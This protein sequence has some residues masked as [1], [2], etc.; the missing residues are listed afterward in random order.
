MAY[1]FITK[2]L[3]E[4]KDKVA[5]GLT[6]RQILCFSPVS[7]THLR[8]HE[9]QERF[10]KEVEKLVSIP[11]KTTGKDSRGLGTSRDPARHQAVTRRPQAGRK[12][13]KTGKKGR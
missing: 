13:H 8:A 4:V 9:R 10:N 12:S 6:K 5:F 2:D 3:T 7:Y 1:V 11:N